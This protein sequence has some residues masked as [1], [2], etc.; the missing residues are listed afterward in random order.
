MN[1]ELQLEQMMEAPVELSEPS[2]YPFL[3]GEYDE[4]MLSRVKN[5][6]KSWRDLSKR[7]EPEFKPFD[8]FMDSAYM[9][10]WKPTLIDVAEMTPEAEKIQEVL[11]IAENMPEWQEL[12]QRVRNNYVTSALATV[13][14]GETIVFPEPQEGGGGDGEG[15]G[16]DE[17]QGEAPN[18]DDVR[19]SI[20]QAV[21]DA[22]NATEQAE[23]LCQLWG[24][25]AGE[26]LSK[27]PEM[28]LGLARTLQDSSRLP[29]IARMLGRLKNQ[30]FH[31]QMVRS[32]Y[33]PEEMVD[34]TLGNN[35]KDLLP[36]S[37]MYMADPELELIFLLRYMQRAL[38][39]QV[40]EGHEPLESGPI[41]VLLDVSGSMQMSL[42]NVPGVG[43]MTRI[44]WASAIALVLTMLAR[45]QNREYCV[46][47]FDH[48]IRKE[49]NSA[50]GDVTTQDLVDMMAVQGSGGTNFQTA[51]S[52]GLE[53]LEE[54]A[55]DK[56]DMVFVT[57][58]DCVVSQPYLDKFHK[59]KEERQ[60]R[61]LSVACANIE[62]ASLKPFS[63]R[64][65]SVSSV[66]DADEASHE[67]FSLGG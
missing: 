43:P 3:M 17:G 9:S 33:I 51:L 25:D 52:R 47:L 27:D 59:V 23:T 53:V 21:S 44:D 40:R 46:V 56:A 55:F 2:E 8:R 10:L 49:I 12:Q 67:I 61:V 22:N 34:I 39:M 42:G 57:D 11:G 64:V 63:D 32:D 13:V 20:A 48:Y 62:P 36:T 41:I 26:D 5:K 58:G 50:N 14:I 4:K 60:F 7:R 29:I 35:L 31:A 6:M 19:D 18:M 54:S 45:S 24:N 30:M 28:L 65:L 38:M 16:D 37:F 15:E 1:D 66:L